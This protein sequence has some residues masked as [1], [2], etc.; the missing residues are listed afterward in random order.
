MTTVL[1]FSIAAAVMVTTIA[2]SLAIVDYHDGSVDSE[3]VGIATFIGLLIGLTWIAA[4]PAFILSGIGYGLFLFVK[5][6]LAKYA[7]KK[8]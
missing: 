3:D 4:V 8:S 6:A 7:D 1:Y 5:V 2:V